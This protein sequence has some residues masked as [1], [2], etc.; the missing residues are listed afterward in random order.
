MLQILCIPAYWFHSVAATGE[1][2][3]NV[4]AF[5]LS[6]ARQLEKTLSRIELLR[7]AALVAMLRAQPAQFPAVV[8]QFVRSSIDAVLNVEHG[9][10]A[11]GTNQQVLNGRLFLTQ[12]LHSRHPES[13]NLDTSRCPLLQPLPDEHGTISIAVGLLAQEMESAGCLGPESS[14]VIE[15]IL[16]DLGGRGVGATFRIG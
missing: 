5:T 12:A 14:G 2:N 6:R 9:L 4:N 11:R 8:A 15:L 13:A 7:P 16:A 10:C 1:L 3:L